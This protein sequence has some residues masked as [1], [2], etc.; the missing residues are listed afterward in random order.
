MSPHAHPYLERVAQAQDAAALEQVRVEILGR[1][2]ELTAQ[3]RG[4]GQLPQEQRR[5][6]GARLNQLRGQ[7]EQAL[8]ERAGQL[9]G[10]A[11]ATGPAGLPFD[12]TLPPQ[13][14]R[15]GSLHPLTSVEEQI[16]SWFVGMGYEVLEGPEIED[17]WHNFEALN[18]PADHPA[19]AMHDT[20]YL[21]APQGQAPLLLRTHTSPMQVRAMRERQPP[22]AVVC[23]GRVYRRD[24]DLTHTPMFHQ[25]EGLFIGSGL[26]MADLKGTLTG[27]CA[28]LFGAHRRLRFR[29]SYFPFTEPSAEVDIQCT[30]GGG[31]CRTCSHSGWLEI[32]G[33]GMV[34][35]R[36]LELN[37]LDPEEHSGFAFGLGV[38]RIAM[39][40][41]GL[42]DMRLNF[43]ND[44]R[45]L[46]QFGPP[47]PGRVAPGGD[48]WSGG[49]D[50][51]AVPSSLAE[52]GEGA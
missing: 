46:R 38:E 39:L 12:P 45:F 21:Q 50:S 29:A 36:V 49:G 15:P 30:C 24:S 33:C 31:G 26:S 4:L 11:A 3:L 8:R 19:R 16:C 43:E 41:H 18:I 5:A 44:L 35:P 14:N 28:H 51:G 6:E 2:G 22:I 23:P 25:V 27:L 32:L 7:V 1:N 47:E 17:D 10:T 48:D 34:H 52:G 40:L 37:G 42:D 9:A 13:G 20:F